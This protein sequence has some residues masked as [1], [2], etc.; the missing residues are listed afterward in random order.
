MKPNFGAHH[1]ATGN[2]WPRRKN[3][4]SIFVAGPI[5]KPRLLH[6]T[7]AQSMITI[8]PFTTATR[9]AFCAILIGTV[10]AV[11]NASGATPIVQ[12]SDAAALQNALNTVPDGGIIEIAA[13]S[14]LDAP[15]QIDGGGHKPGFTI[16]PDL[17]GGTRSF[18][19]RAA[20]GAPVVLSGGGATAVLSLTTPKL[21]TFQGLTFERG[22]SNIPYRGGAIS[23]SGVQANFVSC[24]FRDN[25]ATDAVGAG[26]VWID[27]STV[28]FQG[29]TWTNNTSKTY[30]AGFVAFHSRVFVRDNSFVGNRVNLPGHSQFSAGGAIHGNSSTIFINSS[31]FENNQAGYVGGAIYVIGPWTDTLM[32]LVVSDCL[33]TGNV[34]VH[35]PGVTIP[36]PNTGGAVMMEDQTRTRFYNCRFTNNVARQGGAISSYR[37]NTEVQGC[38]FRNNQAIGTDGADGFGGAIV[39]LSDDNKDDST[40]LGTINRPSAKLTVTDSLIQGPG[41]GVTSARQGGGIFVAG[42]LH[43]NDGV[44]VPK[45]GTPD[46][47]RATVNLKRVAFTDL[48]TSDSGN[49]TGGAMTVNFVALTADSCLVQNCRTTHYGGG[50]EII[51]RSKAN[52]TATQFVGNQGGILGGGLAVFNGGDLNISGSTFADNRLTAPGG[53]SAFFTGPGGA[54]GE[55]MTGAIQDCVITNNSGGPTIYDGDSTTV[56]PYNQVQYNANR[57]N[58]AEAGMYFNPG[59]GYLGIAEMNGLKMPRADGSI[60]SKNSA[61]N[62]AMGSP[63][64]SGAVLMVPPQVRST[65]APGETLP[66]PAFVAFTSSGGTNPSLDGAGQPSSTGVAGTSSDGQH[67]LTVGSAQFKTAPL[68]AAALNIS[69]RLPV[70]QGD[71]ALIGGFI[72]VGPTP[73]R[74]IIRAVG[75]VDPSVAGSALQDPILELH[76]DTGATIATNDNWK[77]TQIG[78][79]LTSNQAVDILASTVPPAN[80]SE[81]AIVASLD[82]LRRYTAIVRGTNGTTGIALVEVYDLDPVQNSTLANISTRGLIQTGNNVMIGGF[83]YLGGPG[84]TKVVARGI[85]PSLAAFVPNPLSDPTL[86]LVNANGQTVSSNDDAAQSPD[87]GAIQAAG[88]LPT[89]SAESAVYATG[90]PRGNYTVIVRGKNSGTGVGLVEVYVF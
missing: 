15:T 43:A 52:I 56:P 27:T 25:A 55:E 58:A 61:L 18:T 14:H 26:S 83:I 10:F 20:P 36:G 42:D 45:N 90:L 8:P 51:N 68:P 12:V 21:V 54:P 74:V 28:S 69:T 24:T 50:V 60:S 38:V 33:F 32:D 75:A 81:S 29:C 1:G 7:S 49:G 64:P 46:T 41:G 57:I 85:G 5:R 84:A 73:K 39:V 79:V 47:N 6:S 4:L 80:D 72:V 31:R 34:A 66:I 89:N 23:L 67:T 19:V 9:N 30:G 13:G 2:F 62:I 71:N 87:A 70:G 63:V 53:G 59:V 11:S 16:Y 78:G 86:D 17:A 40:A 35:D 77:T 48:A 76:D 44:G 22:V 88:L 37:T 65:G 82:P 3:S